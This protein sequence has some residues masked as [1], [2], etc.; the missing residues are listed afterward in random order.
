[1]AATAEQVTQLRRMVAEP[2]E[3]TYTDEALTAVIERYPL[4]DARGLTPYTWDYTTTPPTQV[5]REAWIPTYDL[6]AAAAEVWQEKG[7]LLAG[8]FDFTA[9]GASFSR[10]QAYS[11]AMKQSRYHMARRRMGSREQIVEPRR[12][13]HEIQAVNDPEPED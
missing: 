1:M 13:A 5:L 9:D 12:V 2:T 4:L 3:N 8:N 11:M 7:A 10:S 6:H